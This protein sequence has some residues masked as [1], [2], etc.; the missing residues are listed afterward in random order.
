MDSINFNLATV[1]KTAA[2]RAPQAA[3]Q[4]PKLVIP[5][6]S[7]DTWQKTDADRYRAPF[8]VKEPPKA[9]SG[10]PKLKLGFDIDEN[11]EIKIKP[12]LKKFEVKLIKKF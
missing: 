4:G 3:P 11:T 9:G 10:L 2:P 5:K 12:S 1:N 8:A 6:M 7:A